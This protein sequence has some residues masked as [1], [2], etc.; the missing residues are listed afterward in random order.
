VSDRNWSGK[1][2]ASQIPWKGKR[3]PA[4]SPTWAREN[5]KELSKNK[6]TSRAALRL[7]ES[8]PAVKIIP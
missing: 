6:K 2:T 4:S 8:H 5:R 1:E 3:K 7:R